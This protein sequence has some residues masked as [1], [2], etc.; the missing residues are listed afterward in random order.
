MTVI[1][2]ELIIKTAVVETINN[3]AA[4]DNTKFKNEIVKDCLH[5]LKKTPKQ[6][7]ER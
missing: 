2:K 4:L 5:K 6:K 3:N 7:I 1:I